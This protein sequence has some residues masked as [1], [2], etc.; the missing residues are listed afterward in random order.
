MTVRILA[1]CGNGRGQFHDH[2]MSGPVLTQSNIDHGK[3]LRGW[4]V[5]KR[6]ERRGCHHRFYPHIAGEISVTGSK[7]CGWRAHNMLSPADFNPK[8]LV[9]RTFPQDVK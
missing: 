3:Q 9:I 7:I 4:R 2:E 1:V 5:Q 6:V 8:L